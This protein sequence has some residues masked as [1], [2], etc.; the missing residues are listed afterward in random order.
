LIT[1]DVPAVTAAGYLAFVNELADRTYVAPR[2]VE[3]PRGVVGLRGMIEG[4]GTT[5]V[6]GV[7]EAGNA[8]A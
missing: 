6:G 2:L 7:R 8:F 5:A 4:S 3:E 1:P